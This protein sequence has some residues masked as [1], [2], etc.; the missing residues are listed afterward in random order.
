MD[1]AWTTS[2]VFCFLKSSQKSTKLAAW[3]GLL[4]LVNSFSIEFGKKLLPFFY[5]EIEIL[6][7]FNSDYRKAFVHDYTLMTVYLE[8]NPIEKYI[9]KLHN[10]IQES[11]RIFFANSIN[12][13]LR[14][15]DSIAREDLWSRW[16]KDYWILRNKSIPVKLESDEYVVMLEW[17][18]LLKDYKN[19]IEIAMNSTVAHININSFLSE[20][21]KSRVLFYYPEETADLLIYLLNK[22]N[23][24]TYYW[25][26]NEIV[27]ELRL[28]G[29]SERK[30]SNL[31]GFIN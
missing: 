27:E 17:L 13:I 18:L 11:D 10:S 22:A 29:V 14:K 6:K 8:D 3:E 26:L 25:T 16:L 1:P 5:D 31:K 30:L 21:K 7:E 23:C 20:L 15:M 2:H 12:N 28:N 4:F 19:N 24:N 9:S